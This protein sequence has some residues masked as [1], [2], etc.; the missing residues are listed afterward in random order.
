MN[1]NDTRHLLAYIQAADNRNITPA[2]IAFWMETLPAWL[3][4]DTAKAAVRKFFT[5]PERNAET[6][7]YFTTRH[8][9]RCAKQVRRERETEEARQRAKLPAIGARYETPEGG[10]RARV[11]GGYPEPAENPLE[12]TPMTAE[13]TAAARARLAEMMAGAE[14]RVPG[15]TQLTSAEERARRERGL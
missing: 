13:Q 6:S 7:V 11:P 3:D 15:D 9:I 8:L 12:G 4:L 1:E 14:N 2:D 5:E 10:W